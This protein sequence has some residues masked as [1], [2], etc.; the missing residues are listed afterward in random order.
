MMCSEIVS[1]RIEWG[2]FACEW[3]NY[4]NLWK[5][6]SLDFLSRPCHV[7]AVISLLRAST[8]SLPPTQNG[9]QDNAFSQPK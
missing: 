6:N 1:Q 5:F 9:T 7:V 2:P 4:D 3:K 8:N